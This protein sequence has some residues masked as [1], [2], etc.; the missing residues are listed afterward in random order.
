M[1]RNQ[2][3][4]LCGQ[5]MVEALVVVGVVVLLVT[6]LVSATTASLGVSRMSKNKT[7]A[8]QYA[9]EGLEIVRIVKNSSWDSVPQTTQSFCIAKGQNDLGT[10]LSV[11]PYDIDNFFSRMVTISDSGIC[12]ALNSC[13]N[14]S[15]TVSWKESSQ[16]K[17]VTLTSFV[18]NW[19]TQQ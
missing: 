5:S 7:Q 2:P 15:V 18:T 12:T 19:K 1:R 16:D 6:G 14:V 9:K 4:G 11:C 8:L 13:R 10:P 3:R 17:S